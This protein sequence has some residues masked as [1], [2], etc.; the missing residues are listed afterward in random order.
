MPHRFAIC[1][2]FASSYERYMSNNSKISDTEYQFGNNH[3]IVPTFQL[4]AYIREMG[5]S[6]TAHHHGR[7]SSTL[8]ALDQRRIGRACATAC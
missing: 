3:A 8:S 1:L 5:Y 2:G 6:A 4:A 7:S